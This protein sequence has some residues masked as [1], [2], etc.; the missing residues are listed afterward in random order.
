MSPPPVYQDPVTMVVIVL[1]L[2][3][4]FGLPIANAYRKDRVRRAREDGSQAA[5]LIRD[6]GSLDLRFAR[7]E[8]EEPDYQSVRRS[9]LRRLHQITGVSS[10]TAS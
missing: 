6:I 2:F 4:L 3:A 7:E 5:G 8:L 10:G 1:T 9:L